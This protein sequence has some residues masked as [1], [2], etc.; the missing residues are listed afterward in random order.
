MEK[1]KNLTLEETVVLA[2]QNYK[3]SNFQ[4]AIEQ[5]REILKI[6]SNIKDVQNNLGVALQATGKH[7]EAISCYE[8][9]IKIDP[10]FSNCHSNLGNAFNLIGEY[11][12]AVNCY[13]NA[14]KI[15]P[16][17]ADAYTNLGVIFK[18]LENN[19]KSKDCFEKS[20]KLR[21]NKDPEKELFIYNEM[22]NRLF[23][24]GNDLQQ[25]TIETN[26]LPLL[27]WPLLDF[28]KN[29]DLKNVVLYELGS[30][31]STFWFS[32]I[33]KQIKSYETNSDWYEK[34]KPLLKDN[35]SIKLTSLE[36]IYE[37]SINFR[38]SD[39]LLIDFAGKR[40][41]FI[42]KL[43]QLNDNQIPAQIILDNSG[44]YRNGAKILIERGYIEIPFHGFKSGK[45]YIDC[46]SLFLLRNKF[47]LKINFKFY[48]PTLSLPDF[49]N[50]WD[51]VD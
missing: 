46:T 15:N 36:N 34:L 43:V 22:H 23:F 6:N 40:T 26:Q 35:A 19:K 24:S 33:F 21:L 50:E 4:A 11:K 51:T 31:N 16:S 7:K 20:L 12:K 17:F 14:I 42:N 45:K 48:K 2:N 1:N 39:W 37:C 10:E 28:I 18:K 41:R 30:G 44:W 8:N 29:L 47:D 13:E 32:D 49:N 5:Y 25:I 38:T 3:D 9:A 27:T